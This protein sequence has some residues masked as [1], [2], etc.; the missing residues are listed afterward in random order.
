MFRSFC[1]LGINP[2]DGICR[3]RERELAKGVKSRRSLTQ[4]SALWSQHMSPCP[5]AAC[6][7]KGHACVKPLGIDIMMALNP[8]CARPR[9]NLGTGQWRWLAIRRSSLQL[10]R[11][12]CHKRKLWHKSRRAGK[13]ESSYRPCTRLVMATLQMR[14]IRRRCRVQASWL[15]NLRVAH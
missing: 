13:G 8:C 9:I 5:T 1:G 10:R 3:E 2:T 14:L 7:S 6:V 15:W 11:L 4:Q 12:Q